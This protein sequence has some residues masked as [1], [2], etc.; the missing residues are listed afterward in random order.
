M[1]NLPKSFEDSFEHYHVPVDLKNIGIMGDVHIPYHSNAAIEEAFNYFIIKKVDAI[2]LNG[3]IIDCYTLSKYNPDPRYRRFAD[4]IFAFQQ[5]IKVIKENITPNIY[6][7]L[8]NHEERYERKMILKAPEF[9]DVPVFDFENVMG[10]KELGVNVIADQR[11]VYLGKLPVLHGHEIHMNYAAVNPARTLFLR[12]YKSSVCS[13]LHKTSNH[14]E[15][16]GL[17]DKTLS[18]WST[19]CLCGLHP[20]YKRINSWNHG[21]TRVEKNKQG[22]FEVIN[23]RIFKNKLYI[24]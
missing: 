4:E 10:C 21:I 12:T 8:G 13:H 14:T 6:Y 22:D 20:K 1:Y 3:D 19:G 9:L 16:S 18:T 23:F 5:F 15:Q 11:I 7:K 24:M 2:L 17:D